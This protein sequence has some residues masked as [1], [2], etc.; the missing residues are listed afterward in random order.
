MSDSPAARP[1]DFDSD[2]PIC[3]WLTGREAGLRLDDLQTTIWERMSAAPADAT[4][5]VRNAVE[6]V[7]WDTDL[8]GAIARA[9][10]AAL[11]APG[12]PP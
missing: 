2:K 9:V 7:E 6:R 10:L 1:I 3:I 11:G 12:T 4:E 8:T 5:A